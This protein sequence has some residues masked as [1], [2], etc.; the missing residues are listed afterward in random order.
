MLVELLELGLNA[1]RG[2]LDNDEDAFDDASEIAQALRDLGVHDGSVQQFEEIAKAHRE[3]R[4]AAMRA[5]RPPVE[6]PPFE[7]TPSYAPPVPVHVTPRPGRNEPC[8]CGSNKKYK[9]CHLEADDA[10]RTR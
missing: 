2:G 3:A 7:P 5:S 10:A 4:L 8:W 1:L 6:P 9:K